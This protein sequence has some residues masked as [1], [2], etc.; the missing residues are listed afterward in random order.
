MFTNEQRDELTRQRTEWRNRNQRNRD[1]DQRTIQELRSEL[2][3]IRESIRRDVL[4]QV[5]T[6]GTNAS[7]T[8]V[9]QV[10]TGTRTS[11]MMRGRNSQVNEG[12]GRS[13]RG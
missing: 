5:D 3:S 8:Q 9:S 13:G 11:T 2:N 6:S 10:T 1:D 4:D 12:N 7:A